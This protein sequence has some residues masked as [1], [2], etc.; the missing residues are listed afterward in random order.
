MSV[1][2]T[3]KVFSFLLLVKVAA[4][5]ISGTIYISYFPCFTKQFL[6]CEPLNI[7]F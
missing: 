3:K 7:L 4:N 1:M 2:A 5:I 6:I